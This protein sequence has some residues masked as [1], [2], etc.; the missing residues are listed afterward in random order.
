VI[1]SDLNTRDEVVVLGNYELEQG[2]PVSATP[3]TQFSFLKKG[4][5]P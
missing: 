3:S 4:V 5:A 2:M 1:A